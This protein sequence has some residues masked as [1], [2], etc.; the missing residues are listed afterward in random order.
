M[1]DFI[2]KYI[3]FYILAVSLVAFFAYGIDKSKSKHGKWRI[4]EK[5]LL[6]ICF[7]GGF[8]GGFLGMRAFHHKTKH[9]YFHAAVIVSSLLWISAVALLWFFK[10]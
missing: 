1:L 3:V 5:F 8:L 7:A 4:P 10:V 6:G 9:W 2:S